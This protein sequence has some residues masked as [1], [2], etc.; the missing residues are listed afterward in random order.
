[1]VVSDTQWKQVSFRSI[2]SIENGGNNSE[3][4]RRVLSS[5]IVQLNFLFIF[6][7][8]SAVLRELI[9]EIYLKGEFLF[10][11]NAVQCGI[12]WT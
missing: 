4:T 11:S 1:M 6:S 3:L 2:I 5:F 8:F 12:D 9:E 10:I 7:R